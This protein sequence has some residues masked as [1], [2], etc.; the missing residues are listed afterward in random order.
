MG[1]FLRH[2]VLDVMGP[3][4]PCES[5]IIRAKDI[6]GHDRRHS[7]VSC[8][9]MAALNDL[10]FGLWTPWAEGRT[11]SVVFARWRHVPSWR[12][13]VNRLSAVA[14]QPYVKLL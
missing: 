6:P 7:A 1:R 8:A 14:M 2:D 3:D 5:A 13:R 4:P 11:S 12:I 9:K 10:S